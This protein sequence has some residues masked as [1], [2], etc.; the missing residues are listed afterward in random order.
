[1]ETAI[2]SALI[3]ALV[4]AGGVIVAFVSARWQLQGRMSALEVKRQEIEKIGARL[5]AEAEALRQTLM[6]DVLGRRMHAYAALWRVFITY[7]RN[8]LLEQK[9]FD[10][11]WATEFLLAFNTCNA[12]HGVFFSEHVYRPFYEYRER[13]LDI[14]K[15][16]KS[17][18]PIT[19]DDVSRLMEVSSKGIGNMTALGTAMKDDLGSY[20]RVDIQAG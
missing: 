16:S 18:Q 7:E 6:R 1:M 13:L 2:I 8:W 17:R 15:K 5:Q 9:A 19:E 3:A 10:A 11:A 20:M 4:S 12:E 14:V